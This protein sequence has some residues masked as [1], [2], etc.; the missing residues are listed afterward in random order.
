DTGE[1]VLG[2]SASPGVAGQIFAAD[3]TPGAVFGFNTL[4][5][6]DDFDIAAIAGGRFAITWTGQSLFTAGTSD[7]FVR[8]FSSN[9]T[10]DSISSS[11]VT[12]TG[13]GVSESQPTVTTLEDGRIV[14]SW[15]AGDDVFSQLVDVPPLAVYATEDQG[16]PVELPVMIALSDTDGSEVLDEVRIESLPVG[17]TLAVG[18]R[19]GGDPSG[20]W[21]I[22]RSMP[23]GAD[24]LDA[25][26]GNLAK[27]ELALPQDYN[28]DFTLEITAT[29]RE[30]ANDD[31]ATSATVFVPVSVAPV[32]DAPVANPDT[33]EIFEQGGVANLIGDNF[34]FGELI[35]GDLF[36]GTADTDVDTLTGDLSIAG[37]A[38]GN[39]SGPLS[40]S[41]MAAGTYGTLTADSDGDYNYILDNDSP[42]VQAQNVGDTLT[43][44]F[45]Y[46]VTDNTGLTDTATFTVTINGANDAPHDIAISNSSITGGVFTAALTVSDVD[47]TVFTFNNTELATEG[48]Q[49]V[50]TPGNYVLQSTGGGFGS[51]FAPVELEITATDPGGLSVTQTVTVALSVR[52]Y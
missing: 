8:T 27:L 35:E 38:A 49:V 14:V 1:F 44:I 13:S 6:L 10:A 23:G 40:G 17:F 15:I 26:A 52:V 47:D 21:I 48:F 34:V 16:T 42:L 45:S 11:L 2:W 31:T 50:G 29:S 24:L 37:V 51:P 41:N 28:G 30:T 9:G 3:G 25:L 32:A 36:G 4:L 18:E 5:G 46:T 7:V 22:D 12:N 19:E 20:A 39:V 33:N 43:D